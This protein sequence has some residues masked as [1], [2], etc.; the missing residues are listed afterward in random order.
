MGGVHEHLPID[1]PFVF[2]WTMKPMSSNL[3][4]LRRERSD[5]MKYRF[6]Y[7]IHGLLQQYYASFM[8][9]LYAFLLDVINVG[10]IDFTFLITTP[11]KLPRYA[12]GTSLTI[13]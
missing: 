2:C 8:T 4:S 5:A 9:A 7:Y 3:K 10:H 6:Y 1:K 11:V 12:L 13:S